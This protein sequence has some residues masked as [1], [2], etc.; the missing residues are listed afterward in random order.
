M[1]EARHERTEFDGMIVVIDLGS[2]NPGSVINM[3]RYLGVESVASCD[4]EAIRRAE[5]VILP[6]VG[7]FD[8]GMS[9]LERLEL[10]PVLQE[11]II[12]RSVPLLGI[13]LG[14]QMLTLRSD[15]GILPGLGWIQ[16]ETK[17]FRFDSPAPSYRI[18]HM[19]WNVAMP[20]KKSV[21]FDGLDSQAR[22]YFVHSYHVVC[23][24]NEDIVAST[25]YGYDFAC[26]VANNN[27][28]GVQFH[29]E[30]SH[31]Y[32]LRLL[33]NFVERF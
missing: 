26:C 21:L 30:K 9:A 24:R 31:K 17:R 2:G 25:H 3:L 28:A 5:K 12:G 7:S 32:G 16:G 6:G 13:C 19:G 15:E 22:F 8:T 29:P 1:K 18:P 20:V 27:I 4:V 10:L 14:M 11:R 23:E 33:K